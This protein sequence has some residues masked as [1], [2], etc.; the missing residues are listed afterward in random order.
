MIP[1]E[2]SVETLRGFAQTFADPERDV[3]ALAG[4]LVHYGTFLRQILDSH[5]P[6]F[7]RPGDTHTATRT[8]AGGANSP[9]YA[10]SCMEDRTRTAAFIRGAIRAVQ[11]ALDRG[12]AFRDSQRRPAGRVFLIGHT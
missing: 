4:P 9:W 2:D 6:S 12:A 3:R 8:G 5:R 1:V 10:A 7:R 11:R